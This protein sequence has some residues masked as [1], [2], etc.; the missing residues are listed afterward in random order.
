MGNPAKGLSI[1]LISKNQVF[2]LFLLLLIF[3]FLFHLFALT[4][5]LLLAVSPVCPGFSSALRGKS[6]Y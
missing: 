2:A 5:S 4:S 3:P 1:S 6:D